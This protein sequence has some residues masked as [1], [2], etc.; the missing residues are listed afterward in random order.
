MDLSSSLEVRN[1]LLSEYARSRGALFRDGESLHLLE[2]SEVMGKKLLGNVAILPNP[3]HCS[4]LNSAAKYLIGNRYA[5]FYE[6]HCRHSNALSQ[7]SIK[8]DC[9]VFNSITPGAN[10]DLI[11]MTITNFLENRGEIDFT[12]TPGERILV[13]LLRRYRNYLPHKWIN[14]WKSPK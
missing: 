9:T 5:K 8:V 3:N 7:N 10:A 6:V 13:R 12:L 11:V 4:E 2:A 1:S 14:R